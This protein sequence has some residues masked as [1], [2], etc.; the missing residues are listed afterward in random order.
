MVKML[1][2]T[3]ELELDIVKPGTQQKRASEDPE[4]SDQEKL[5]HAAQPS[6][7]RNRR[8]VGANI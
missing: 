8:G 5:S 7:D 4:L 3:V 6:A 2:E 1:R